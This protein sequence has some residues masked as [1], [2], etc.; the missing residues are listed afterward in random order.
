MAATPALFLLWNRNYDS[1]ID[2]TWIK[3]RSQRRTV[4]LLQLI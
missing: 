3:M 2:A 4:F 1:S